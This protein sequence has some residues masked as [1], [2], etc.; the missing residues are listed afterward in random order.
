MHILT[1][2][3]AL[4]LH[5]LWKTGNYSFCF[6][7]SMVIILVSLSS[8]HG[9]AKTE[10]LKTVYYCCIQVYNITSFR[11]VIFYFR[12]ALNAS[13]FILKFN[14]TLSI[15][16]IFEQCTLSTLSPISFL[17]PLT[18]TWN[19]IPRCKTS[20]VFSHNIQRGLQFN[21]TKLS[22]IFHI[23]LVL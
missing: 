17:W 19:V 18:I 9:T 11:N 23:A 3:Q 12:M 20:R 16:N 4:L 7:N 10:R 1:L 2:T 15:N 14:E 5:F 13:I 22:I 8:K 21:E 6:Y